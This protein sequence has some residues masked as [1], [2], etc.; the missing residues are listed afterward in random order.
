MACDEEKAYWTSGVPAQT[1]PPLPGR[2]R[3]DV[4]IIG[5]GIVGLTLAE[6]LKRAGRNAVVVEN[7]RVGAQVTGRSTA[8]LTALHG[9]VYDD[10]INRHG[11][12]TARAYAEANTAAMRHVEEMT[13]EYGIDCDLTPATAYT[14]SEHGSKREAIEREVAA[15][16]KAGLPAEQV[17][18]AVSPVDFATGVKLPDQFQFQPYHYCA[19][20]ARAVHGEGA[21]I[22]EG[23][24]AYS[25]HVGPPHEVMTDHGMI[26]AD[27]V[28]IATNL[29]FMD[30]GLFFAKASPRQHVV[31]AARLPDSTALEGM[32]L[33]VDEPG[34]SFRR[35]NG[36]NGPVLILTGSGARPG[37]HPPAERLA[38]LKRLA[39]EKFGAT[40]HIGWW[41]NEDYD[42]VDHLPYVGPLTPVT[43]E[44]LVATGFSAWGLTNGTA[45]AQMLARHIQGEADVRKT[46]FSANRWR[47]RASGKQLLKINLHVGREFVDDR[48]KAFGARE[49]KSLG[50]GEGG[51]C[52]RHG[53]AVAAYRDD[54]GTLHIM[55]PKCPHLKCFV[56]WNGTARTWE[57]PCHGSVFSCDGRM[58]HGPAVR[59]MKR[60]E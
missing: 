35:H 4:A 50:P 24:R 32:F 53:R 1:Y 10:L 42:S 33:N 37:H 43:P 15:A 23:T 34:Y 52:R 28:V 12:D 6:R 51:I 7:G 22:H 55:S 45:A 59:D 13:R 58:L 3:C 9:L 29:P 38:K 26:T 20:M 17:S 11:L 31:L 25:V 21:A 14:I 27:Y 19:G 40:E 57:C 39:E 36:E 44:I 2:T 8:K 48:R 46:P 60:L 47:L 30:R 41:F 56:A 54:D 18:G 16:V 5:G 49:A